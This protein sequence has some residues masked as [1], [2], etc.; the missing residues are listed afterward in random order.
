MMLPDTQRVF[1]HLEPSCNVYCAAPP[2]SHSKDD[3]VG[4][5]TVFLALTRQLGARTP[6]FAGLFL[7]FW[8][9]IHIVFSPP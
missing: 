6:Y 4:N 1:S 9:S 7:L 8:N 2:S 3:Q 5:V